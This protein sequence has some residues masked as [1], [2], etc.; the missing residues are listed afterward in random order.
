MI[1]DRPVLDVRWAMP[2]AVG[3]IALVV[4]LPSPDRLG[5]AAAVAGAVSVT[6]LVAARTW[7]RSGRSSSSRAVGAATAVAVSVGLAGLLLAGAAVRHDVRYPPEL[8][9]LVG[10]TVELDATA[11]ERLTDASQVA[12]L[13]VRSV[14]SGERMWQGRVSMLVLAPR[15]SGAVEVGQR[16][17][18]RA[19]VLPVEPG[20]DAAFVVAARGELRPGAPASGSA[21]RAEAMRASFRA[22]AA[23]L[24][25]DGGALLPGL[26]IGDTSAVPDDLRDAMRTSSLSHLTAVSGSNCAVLVALTMLVGG[27]LG[28]PRA[29][30]VVAAS[31]VLLAFLVLVTPDASIVRATVMALVVLGHLAGSRPVS[32]LPVVA[33][34]VT[35]MLMAD[36]W[37]SRDI[38]FALTVLATAGL[39]VLAAP[40]ARLLARVMPEPLALV[41]AV[42]I[43]AQLACGPVLLLL[44]PGLPLHGVAANVL[45]EPAAPVATVLGL[46]VCV[47]AGWAPGAAGLVAGVAWAPASWVAAVARSVADWPAA[48]V[49]WGQGIVAVGLLAT[50]T[51]L[52]VVLVLAGRRSRARRVAAAGLVGVVVIAG[53]AVLG[54]GIGSRGSVPDDWTV[55]QCDVGQG[56]AV[57]VRSAAS[58]ALIDTGDDEAALDRCLDL[59]GVDRVDLLVLTHFDTDHV[60]AVAA[61]E[62]RVDAALVGPTGRSADERVVERLVAAGVEVVDTRAGTSGVLGE[63]SWEVLW[64]PLEGASPPP[65]NDASL[66]TRFRP[67][68]GCRAGCLDLMAL[69]D[70]GAEAQRRLSAT[71]KLPE[72]VDVVKVAHHGSA[73]QDPGLYRSL[74]AAVA[75]VGV[76]ADN[77]YGHPT[78]SLL[79][80]LDETA[81]AVA[82]SDL[83]GS[84][85]VVVGDGGLR[86][87]RERASSSE[88]SSTLV[89]ASV[90]HPVAG[91]GPWPRERVPSRRRRPVSPSIRSDGTESGPP[92]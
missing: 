65:G 40:L 75:L 88:A 27:A 82:R 71:G 79:A 87:W 34:A 52:V 78:D 18:L 16:V 3:W 80:V 11:S 72:R 83:D 90:P 32:G 86:L 48:R 21:G 67:T 25:G 13:D 51:G 12:S 31:V 6:A 2:A 59:F 10:H 5:L 41:L 43:A 70:L 38:G 45:A 14:T 23:D 8:T 30:R 66:V 61:V 36:P 39:V 28:V 26:T 19:T 22:V 56:D 49:E 1:D 24:P 17:A 68:A 46:L 89:A 37:I 50:L 33:V 81:S 73:D 53:G 15:V 85:A 91:G 9:A 35:G 63:S 4:L 54:S 76:G 92:P 57:L 42:P 77:T 7:S 69:G 55:A 74:G 47:L 60:G 62:R 20:G 84:A 44:D 64:P 29:V 58:V